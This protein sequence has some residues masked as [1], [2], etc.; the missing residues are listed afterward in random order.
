MRHLA[1]LIESTEAQVIFISETKNSSFKKID[2]INKFNLDNAHIISADGHSS[3]LWVLCRSQVQL[4][5][6]ES[7]RFYVLASCY[8]KH[9]KKKFGLV[10]VCGDP[11][12]RQTMWI[13]K[14]IFAFVM[15]NQ[16]LP[17]VCMGDMNNIMHV[18]EKLNPGP[19]NRCLISKF[20]CLVK[21]C[22]FFDLGFKGPAYT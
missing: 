19:V 3:G 11:Y 6:V 22:G 1:R 2:L 8:H 7:C 4:D 16:D 14:Q 17:F 15:S 5:V 12:H 13:W 20:R 9:V 10:C 21:D 18:S